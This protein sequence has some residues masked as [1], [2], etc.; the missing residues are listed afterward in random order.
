MALPAFLRPATP[1]RAADRRIVTLMA[2]AGFIVAFAGS[3]ITHALPFIRRSLLIT[4]GQMSFVFAFTRFVALAAILFSLWG[5]RRGRR[6][7]FLAAFLIIPF[8]NLA[9]AMLPGPIF[10]TI[11]Q[12][13]TRIGVMAVTGLAIVL[14]AEELEPRIRGYGIAVY[15]LAAALGN[16]TSL[17]LL[18]IADRSDEAWRF[19][20]GLSALGIFAFPMLAR[21]LRESRAFR[22]PEYHVPLSA[23]IKE[24]HGQYVWTLGAIA[25]FVSAFASPALDFGLERLIDDLGWTTG[26]ARLL[27]MVASGI[28]VTGLLAGGRLADSVGR[29]PTEI[30]AIIVGLAGG[31]AFYFLESGPALAVG[32]FLGTFGASALSPALA[33]H[34]TELFPTR[35]RATASA[36]VA[37]SGI[38]GS[39]AGF[40]VG[41]ALIDAIGLSATVGLLGIG[42]VVAVGLIFPLPETKGRDLTGAAPAPASQQSVAPLDR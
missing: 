29:R 18:P 8:A 19:L 15:A 38:V 36:W 23:V 41:A 33:A 11:T 20:F 12:A 4:E 5:D 28:G 10:F 22:V 3:L 6:T 21:F 39:I 1:F 14:L 17:L 13:V 26:S 25:F 9:T 42:L 35:M 40:L 30:F 27:V 24:G 7:P 16:G 37:N 2:V 31:L 34:R 32:L